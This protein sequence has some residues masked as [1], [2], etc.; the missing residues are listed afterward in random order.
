MNRWS[1]YRTATTS[2]ITA[3]YQLEFKWRRWHPNGTTTR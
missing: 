3:L 2:T 1:P